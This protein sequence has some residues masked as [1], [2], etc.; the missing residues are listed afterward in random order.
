MR[1]VLIGYGNL[2]TQ[3]GKTLHQN[4]VNVVQ[5]YGRDI[6][7]ASQLAERI[8]AQAVCAPECLDCTA[9]IYICALK[10]S[11]FDEVL[12]VFPRFQ[13]LLVHTAGSVSMD[14]LRSYSSRVGV[15]YPLQTFSMNR[16]VD[17]RVIPV[18]VEASN[19]E[20][21]QMLLNLG[22]ILTTQVYPC[23]S[24]QRRWLHLAAVFA[25]NF[26]NY[27]YCLS[28]DLLDAHQL[29]FNQ[30]LPLIDETARKVHEM[31]PKEAQTGPATRYDRN[32]MDAHMHMLADRPDVQALY[33]TMSKHI[34]NHVNNEL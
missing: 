28:S 9:D 19:E 23:S 26:V 8:G 10:D 22:K 1:V 18:Y 3:L 29:D 2:A 20:D 34:F 4:A 33:E 21:E 24:E 7:K 32:I 31:H 11:V 12:S 25:C 30:L 16:E 27:L 13:G 17:F 14:V 5:V 6:E 15:F